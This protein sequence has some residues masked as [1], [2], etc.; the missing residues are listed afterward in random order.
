MGLNI[1]EKTFPN[2]GEDDFAPWREIPTTII[3][4]ELNRFG[5]MAA[6]IKPV[7]AGSAFVGEALTV[8][9]IAADNAAL[10]Y[11]MTKAWPGAA[12]VVDAGAFTDSAVWGGILHRVGVKQ[13]IVGVVVDGAVRDLAELRGSSVPVYARGVVPAGPHKGWGGNINTPIQCGGCPVQP[14][15]LVCGDDDGVVVVPRERMAA[16]LPKCRVRI[17]NEQKWE[18]EIENGALTVDLLNLPPAED[19]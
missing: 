14:G 2:L 19:F 16:L 1:E 11:A 18:R 13:G 6:A 8:Q 9:V 10:H 4:D 12:L 15:D 17:A 7:R 3:S 5:A